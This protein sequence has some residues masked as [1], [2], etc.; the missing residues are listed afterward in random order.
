MKGVKKL[1]RSLLKMKSH[2]YDAIDKE[3]KRIS[4]EENITPKQ[5]HDNFKSANNGQIPDDW[6]KDQTSTDNSEMDDQQFM[7]QDGKCGDCPR[8]DKKK[9]MIAIGYSEEAVD[10][11]FEEIELKYGG[12]LKGKQKSL[13]ENIH[14]KRKRIKAGSGER[15]R[16]K[17]EKGAPETLNVAEK[18]PKAFESGGYGKGL[19]EKQQDRAAA[20][21]RKAMK[22]EKEG[23]GLKE[24]YKPWKTDKEHN[25]KLKEQGK[26]TPKS[27]HTK[28]YEQ[29]FG[30]DSEDNAES[31]NFSAGKSLA[32]KAEKSGISAGILRKVYKR[33]IGA[34]KS[35]HRPGMS[36]QQWAMARVN[37]FLTGGGARKA[38]MDLWKQAKGQKSS[39][40]G[41][42]ERQGK[43][44]K[45]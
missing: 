23:K 7:C 10:A 43:K 42:G 1:E 33:G 12:K 27:K 36:P 24:Q 31:E 41:K 45:S 18:T 9:E 34:W 44:R 28:K 11:V 17:G 20:S 29:M 26:K 25:K 13:W 40:G 16:K 38:D 37:S 19:S 30:K 8:C 15:M 22:A 14:A 5:L 35:G 2:S 6:I 32:K 4:K 21:A 39:S 3:M